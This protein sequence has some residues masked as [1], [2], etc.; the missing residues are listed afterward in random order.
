MNRCLWL[1]ALALAG[2]SAHAGEL[3]ALNAESVDLGSFRGIVYY[4][5]ETEGYRVVATLGSGTEGQPIR[6]VSTLEPGQRMLIS[7]PQAVGQPSI[8]LEIT[9]DGDALLVGESGPALEIDPTVA[10]A[11][12][13]V[14]DK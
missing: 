7:L 8:D 11:I 10:A 14:I 4:T 1:A 2:S 12:K 9:R 13:E 6:F 3:A 5:V